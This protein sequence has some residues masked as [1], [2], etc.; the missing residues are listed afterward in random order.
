MGDDG[1]QAA[2]RQVL[3]PDQLLLARS[4][5]QLADAQHRRTPLVVAALG[6]PRHGGRQR[7]RGRFERSLG[8]CLGV[9]RRT[10]FGSA[11]QTSITSPG[12]RKSRQIGTLW[13]AAV[14]RAFPSLDLARV[15]AHYGAAEGEETRM[16]QPRLLLIDDEPALADF[17][18]SAAARERLRTR[19]S[20][21]NDEEFRDDFLAA[22][23][24]HGRARP[25]DAG[26]GRGRA[27]P[28]PR[29]AGLSRAGADRQRIRPARARIRLP[30]R[31]SARPDMA[32]PLEKPVRL[33]ELEALLDAA[34]SDAGDHDPQ[35]PT[36]DCSRASSAR[37]RSSGCTW[38]TSPRSRCATAA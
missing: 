32:G 24:R 18:A 11:M 6:R 22:A 29:R 13:T 35:R 10:S 28:L 36:S 16:T 4:I 21:S 30:P 26:N 19:R 23:A 34:S 12:A 37:S 15:A 14:K 2:G 5:G 3:D 7:N 8:R 9:R 33:E 27:A 38:S 17:L 31:R 1:H 25:R 20:P